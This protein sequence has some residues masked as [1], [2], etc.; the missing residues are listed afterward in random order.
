MNQQPPPS[1]NPDELRDELGDLLLQIVFQAELA[2]AKGWF[3]PNDVVDAIC[4]KLIRRHPHVFA[5]V[6]VEDADEVVRNWEEIKKKERDMSID[7]LELTRGGV[8]ILVFS[9]NTMNPVWFGHL[10]FM[11]W[12][13]KA[14]QPGLTN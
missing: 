9:A 4:E 1:G 8:I 10:D 12:L 14:A 2:R 11:D 13:P 5:D 7:M 6:S 3:A